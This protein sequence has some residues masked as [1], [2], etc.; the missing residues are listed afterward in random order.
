MQQ[1][2][3]SVDQATTL[4]ALAAALWLEASQEVSMQQ[5]RQTVEQIVT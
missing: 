3:Q 2:V 5:V 4:S 1:V